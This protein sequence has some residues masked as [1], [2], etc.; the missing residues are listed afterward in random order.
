MK[1]IFTKGS[2]KYDLM[3][4]CRDGAEPERV[5]CPKQ[6]IIPHDMVHYAVEHTLET[7]GFLGRLKDG[8]VAAFRM[9]PEAQSDSIERLVEVFQGDEWS[10]GCSS[11]ADLIEMYRVTCLA[12]ECPA[13]PLDEA[14]IQAV[15]STIS[16]LTSRWQCVPVGGALHL[17]L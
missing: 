13:L 8:E 1:F 7:R 14:A 10:G 6:R 16:D 4:V 11:A 2:G 17:E 9:K 15:R 5:E 3:E 12:R